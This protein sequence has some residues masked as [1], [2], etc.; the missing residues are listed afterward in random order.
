MKNDEKEKLLRKHA[1]EL[2]YLESR[3]KSASASSPSGLGSKK[4]LDQLL[5]LLVQLLKAQL[6]K[7]L[8]QHLLSYKLNI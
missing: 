6:L 3:L 7:K 8:Q 5:F 1:T 2:A 4:S